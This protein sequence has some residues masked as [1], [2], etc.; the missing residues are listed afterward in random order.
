ML[1]DGIGTASEVEE[2][3]DPLASRAFLSSPSAL[4]DLDSDIMRGLK[5]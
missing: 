3:L 5:E 2:P 1:K 4:L